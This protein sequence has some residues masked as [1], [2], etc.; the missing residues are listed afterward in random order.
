LSVT[1]HEAADMD[2]EVEVAQE[3]D[4][5]PQTV[6]DVVLHEEVD[7]VVVEVD[8]AEM[9]IT[10]AATEALH[11]AGVEVQGATGPSPVAARTVELDHR[12]GDAVDMGGETVRRERL[13]DEAVQVDVAEGGEAGATI[14]TAVAADHTR[15]A[16]AGIVVEGDGRCTEWHDIEKGLDRIF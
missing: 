10:Q 4:S 12:R 1:D 6:A 8:E 14:A 11:A 7:L 3:G 13:G 2:A 16:V 9:S 5:A 15:G